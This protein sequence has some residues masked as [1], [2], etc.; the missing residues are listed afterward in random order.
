MLST[1]FYLRRL[2]KLIDILVMLFFWSSL[3]LKK[4]LKAKRNSFPKHV[5]FLHSLLIFIPFLAA[6]HVL[7]EC[8]HWI[9]VLKWL[10]CH[11][12]LLSI[13]WEEIL[14]PAV[15]LGIKKLHGLDLQGAFSLLWVRIWV[16]WELKTYLFAILT[17]NQLSFPK[18][19]RTNGELW[20]CSVIAVDLIII[21]LFSNWIKTVAFLNFVF[22]IWNHI[23]SLLKLSWSF[24]D[25]LL[26]HGR[27]AWLIS[28]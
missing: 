22:Q 3:F 10:S 7:L 20:F 9:D 4:I 18:I 2:R 19:I 16:I 11:R 24:T 28:G 13:R 12:L 26:N 14:L 6:L 27:C 25:S 1:W 21:W 17:W 8:N 23:K 5:Y 15:N